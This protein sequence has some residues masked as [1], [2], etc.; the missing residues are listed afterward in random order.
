MHCQAQHRPLQCRLDTLPAPPGGADEDSRLAPDRTH[1]RI[2]ATIRMTRAN[3][4][5]ARCNTVLVAARLNLPTTPSDADEN[6][7]LTP[8]GAHRRIWATIRMT[9]VNQGTARR[10]TSLFR[11]GLTLPVMLM[12]QSVDRAPLVTE[13][14][15][16]P[17][18]LKSQVTDL[19]AGTLV[20]PTILTY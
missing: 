14:N 12:R 19:G 8:F 9:R 3:Q 6:S 15:A 4:G 11:A 20:L 18:A 10:R 2:W 7:R 5:T 16:K 17:V 1:L 13:E